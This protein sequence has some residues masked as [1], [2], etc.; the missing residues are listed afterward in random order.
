MNLDF[1][2]YP[3][4]KFY[5]TK[6]RRMKILFFTSADLFRHHSGR[7]HDP[8][9]P[10]HVPLQQV[11]PHRRRRPH[12]APVLRQVRHRNRKR[13]PD[14]EPAKDPVN[15]ARPARRRRLARFCFSKCC[16]WFFVQYSSTEVSSLKSSTLLRLYRV[17]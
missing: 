1:Q 6:L 14:R 8:E 9:L 12:A 10:L 15:G 3:H 17:C 2:D 16:D 4:K 11:H 13:P 5:D 7:H